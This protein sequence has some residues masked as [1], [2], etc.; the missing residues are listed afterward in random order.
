MVE[1]KDTQIRKIILSFMT[2]I[3]FSLPVH[4]ASLILWS[5][6]THSTT[7]FLGR[8]GNKSILDSFVQ[9]DPGMMMPNGGIVEFLLYITFVALV[10]LLLALVANSLNMTGRWKINLGFSDQQVSVLMLAMFVIGIYV[11]MTWTWTDYGWDQTHLWSNLLSWDEMRLVTWFLSPILM[12][13]LFLRWIIQD[14]ASF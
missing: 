4:W 12:V 9:Y 2:L 10:I 8:N 5:H 7:P 3:L 11:E 6:P 13:V 1:I 14:K